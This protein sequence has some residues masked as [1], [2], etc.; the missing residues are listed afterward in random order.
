VEVF[1]GK[2]KSDLWE[3]LG[4][5]F[6]KIKGLAPIG[7]NNIFLGGKGVTFCEF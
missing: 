3:K 2:E 1:I 6:A 7:V 4:F 5:K